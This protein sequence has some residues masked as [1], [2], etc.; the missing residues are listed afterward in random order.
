M[1]KA[2][3]RAK[4]LLLMLLR[5]EETEMLQELM[6]RLYS[7]QASYIL[8]RDLAQPLL[9]RPSAKIPIRIRPMEP[10]DIRAI[11]AERPRRLPA[12]KANIP[13]CY[14]VAAE[15]GSICFMQWLIKA[16]QQVL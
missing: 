5:G 7:N 1:S 15:D 4:T 6:G 16:A 11:V 13:T 2:A 8:R 9:P 14:V 10:G 12:L 3:L